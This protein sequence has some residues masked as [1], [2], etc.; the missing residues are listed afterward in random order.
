MDD[1][2]AFGPN[3]SVES[4]PRGI[5]REIAAFA[6]EQ[7]GVLAHREL[8][9]LGLKRQ[10]I[11]Y[12]LERG[13]LHELH[14]GVYAVG[15]RVVSTDGVRM[16]AVLA[17][18]PGAV[19]SHRSAAAMW[20][21]RADSRPIVEI[22]VS[23]SRRDR[24][25]IRQHRSELARHEVTVVR[26]IPLT[27]LARTLLDLAAVVNRRQVERAVRQAEYQRILDLREVTALLTQHSRRPG[28]GTLRAV[29]EEG[30]DMRISRSELEERFMDFLANA[31]LPSPEV[32]A[33][34]ELNGT[35]IEVDCLWRA[36]RIVVELDGRQAHGT[37]TAFER[38]RRRDRALSVAGWRP[39]RVTWRQ[40]HAEAQELEH[41]LRTLLASSLSRA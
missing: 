32:N 14:R 13:R 36:E 18:G 40:L 25:G 6:G 11:A 12:R 35:W 15:H 19:L 8:L 17:G 30:T 3:S 24:P 5:E 29:V 39:V 1:A 34:L 16:A 41:D 31:V 28:S 4:Q 2:S 9:A 21:I 10:A 33:A 7:H 37:C 26:G 38:D 22:T 20:G 23:C 27:T